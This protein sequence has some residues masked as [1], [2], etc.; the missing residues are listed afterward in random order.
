MDE[1]ASFANLLSQSTSLPRPTWNQPQTA[2]DPWANPFSD[3]SPSNPFAN[4]A[5]P[6]GSSSTPVFG[7]IP[8]SP[9]EE[10]SPYVQKLE[11]DV[12]AGLGTLPDPPSVIAAREQEQ[13][14][15]PPPA[16]F[17]PPPTQSVLDPFDA[18]P[19]GQPEPVPQFVATPP[20]APSRK[21][22]LD[23]LDDDILGASDPSVS[24]KKAFVKSSAAARMTTAP[25]SGKSKAYVFKPGRGGSSKPSTPKEEVRQGKAVEVVGTEKETK[26]DRLEDDEG[27]VKK[28]EHKTAADTGA[29]DGLEEEKADRPPEEER[30]EP[31]TVS[32]EEKL[33]EELETTDRPVPP[34]DTEIT[35][36]TTSPK[37]NGGP[38]T[39]T[40]P[41]SHLTAASIPLPD[42]LDVT[43]IAT[44]PASPITSSA[45]ENLPE[46]SPMMP[47][48]TPTVDRVAV[49]PLDAPANGTEYGFKALSI[50]GSS[51]LSTAPP[52][53]PSKSPAPQLPENGLSGPPSRF[54]GKGWG[55]MDEEDGGLFGKG[56][57]SLRADPWG[58]NAGGWNEAG[59][60]SMPTS[61][62]PSQ[63]VSPT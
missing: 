51:N 19:F 43:P 32:D 16:A 46:I 33:E 47:A 54:G 2:D 62:G 12:D 11:D 22:P 49:S 23:L 15:A 8:E 41:T 10:T 57:P 17:S 1:E 25:D 56:G 40:G 29:E 59:F 6:F 55:E 26:E 53:P 42:S 45:S 48:I 27:R 38:Q 60:T 34:F 13:E 30:E 7:G 39:S 36:E 5:S 52:P 31:P 44:R 28:E 18:S 35:G 37:Q 21:L 61:A 9:R 3:A 50:G 63:R 24:L 20:A 58:D 4:A 14:Q